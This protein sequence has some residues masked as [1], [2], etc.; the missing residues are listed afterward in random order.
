VLHVFI[1]SFA[2]TVISDILNSS[3]IYQNPKGN[4]FQ[5][6]IQSSITQELIYSTTQQEIIDAVNLLTRSPWLSYPMNYSG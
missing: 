6:K 4:T 3:I 5:L 1:F 2:G